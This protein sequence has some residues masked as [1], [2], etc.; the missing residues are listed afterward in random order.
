MANLMLVMVKALA[1][2]KFNLERL[3]V[4]N[5]SCWLS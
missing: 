2:G 3:P 1:K 4:W 5:A